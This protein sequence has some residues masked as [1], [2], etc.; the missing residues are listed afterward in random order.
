M[1]LSF[2]ILQKKGVTDDN[3]KENLVSEVGFKLHSMMYQDKQFS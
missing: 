1:F 2:Q 3:A